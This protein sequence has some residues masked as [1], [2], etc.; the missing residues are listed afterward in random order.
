MCFKHVTWNTNKRLR[1][2]ASKHNV[3][4]RNQHKYS[5][6]PDTICFTG[7]FQLE[8]DDNNADITRTCSAKFLFDDS[9]NTVF[10]LV[11]GSKACA[12][13]GQHIEHS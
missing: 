6:R 4:H 7:I 10:W 3:S 2:L 12:P 13:A 8:G 9:V 1:C 5:A 11:T